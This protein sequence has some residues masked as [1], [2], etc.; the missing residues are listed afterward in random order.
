MNVK[1]TKTNDGTIS[2]DIRHNKWAIKKYLNYLCYMTMCGCYMSSKGFWPCALFFFKIFEQAGREKKRELLL[3]CVLLCYLTC[4]HQPVP[5]SVR[6]A[7]N[8]CA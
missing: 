8:I 6:L 7:G 1:Q 2:A 4:L 3:V 5:L